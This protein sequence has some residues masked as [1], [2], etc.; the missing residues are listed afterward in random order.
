M[1][2]IHKPSFINCLHSLKC[3]FVDRRGKNSTFLK[4]ENTCDT[5]NSPLSSE[6]VGI[7]GHL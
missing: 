6:V 3:A 1:C 5:A 4:A 7:R 2:V